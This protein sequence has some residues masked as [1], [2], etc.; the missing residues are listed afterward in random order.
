M[1]I[2]R[3]LTTGACAAALLTGA[4]VSL[5]AAGPTFRPDVVF[6]GSTLA[7]WTPIGQADWK[8]QNGE[9]VGTPKS[10]DGGFLVLGTPYQDVAIFSNVTCAGGCKAGMLVRAEKTA[11][12]GMKGVFVS[13]S[14]GDLGSYAVTIDAQ[15][16]ITNRTKLGTAQAAPITQR[17]ATGGAPPAPAG[18]AAQGRPAGPPQ[19]PPG[20][21]LPD[22]MSRPAGEYKAGQTNNVDVTMALNNI[23][24]RF[25]GG[26]LGAAGGATEDA[27]GKYGPIALW[28]GGTA[29]ASFKDV[30]Y[31]DL[32][33]RP[34]EAE[35]VSANFRARR[36]SEFYYSYSTAIAD[37]N[38]DGHQDVVAGPYVYYGPDFSVG[39][40]FYAG[41]TYNPTS[42]WP[43]A[44]MV[45]LAHDWTGDGWPD[46]LNMSG[47]AGNGVGTLFVNPKGENRRWD[48]FVVMQPP[49]GVIGNEE[50]LLKDI[51]GD[52]NLEIIHTGQNTLRY[53]KPDPANPTGP[54]KVT[55]ISEPGPWGVNIS[56]GMGVGDINGDGLMDYTM[57][58]GWWEQPKKGSGQ[59]LWS[60]HP[61]PFGRWGASQGGAG[62]AEMGIYDVNGDKLNDVVTVLEG[63]GFG[64]AWFE[65]KRDAGGKITFVRH[66]IMD[67]A[68][69]KNAGNVWFTQPHAATFA[70]VNMDGLPDMIVG[71][72]H[73]SHFQYADPD[74]WGMPVLYV[75]K[76][77]R[78][79]KAP[80]GAEFVPELIS[81][82]SGVGSHISVAD[83]NKDGTPDITVSGASGTFVFFN[84]YK[85]PAAGR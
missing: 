21:V 63:H 59:T 67:S 14:D 79:P 38:R 77:V 78:N 54:W 24:V 33:A 37:F 70:D 19:M 62:G 83:L 1:R 18:A 41:I 47:N 52:G 80:G 68:L 36:L 6:R 32:N 57:A 81:N 55:T 40:Q 28:V 23:T 42:E 16:R 11:D 85:K 2:T 22:L 66:T 26:S 20:V 72:R 45:Q 56:H 51:D 17:G 64:I 29:P 75:Y 82:R 9:I 74:N 58:Y 46:V 65:Q 4:L 35:K 53:S 12:G 8:A 25:N 43:V 31:A 60:W 27:M 30:A 48:S 76:T 3:L 34:F 7:G 84:N 15:G 44:A 10:A 69:D 73:H 5:D 49:D 13:I 39:R 50:T 71:K 61:E